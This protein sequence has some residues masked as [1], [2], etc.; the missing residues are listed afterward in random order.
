M[1]NGTAGGVGA[2]RWNKWTRIPLQASRDA[3]FRSCGPPKVWPYLL[4]PLVA[5]AMRLSPNRKV[6][7]ADATGHRGLLGTG[8][9]HAAAVKSDGRWRRGGRGRIRAAS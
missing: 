3:P 5:V 1:A 6:L 2:N 7:S 9:N 8:G 4:R